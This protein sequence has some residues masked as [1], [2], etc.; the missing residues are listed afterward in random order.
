MNDLSDQEQPAM[1][2]AEYLEAL[3]AHYEDSTLPRPNLRDYE[4]PDNFDDWARVHQQLRRM[5]MAGY[6]HRNPVYKIQHELYDYQNCEVFQSLLNRDWDRMLFWLRLGSG[7]TAMDY[8]EIAAHTPQGLKD[9]VYRARADGLRD[10]F[11]FISGLLKAK[12][13]DRA[14][15]NLEFI[16]LLPEATV[17]DDT[18]G[19]Y[20]AED[21]APLNVWT[22]HIWPHIIGLKRNKPFIHWRFHTFYQELFHATP[23][24]VPFAHS[25]VVAMALHPRA[26]AVSALGCLPPEI[27]LKNILRGRV[28]PKPMRP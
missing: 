25:R 24:P 20:G 16:E 23:P 19:P 18:T 12:Q 14:A 6:T 17:L 7:M 11:L 22:Q 9:T 3:H 27:L 2:Y 10:S 26:K 28:W 21:G 15:G 1:G 4:S 8:T 5:Y 13:W